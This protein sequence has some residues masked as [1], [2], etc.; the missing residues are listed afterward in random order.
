MTLTIGQAIH[1]SARLL[2]QACT[3]INSLMTMIQESVNEFDFKEDVNISGDW[4]YDHI[5]DD[6]DFLCLNY[7]A[8]LGLKQSR[9]KKTQCYL[10]IEFSL[11]GDG[12]THEE[13]NNQEPLVHISLWDVQTDYNNGYCF[14]LI[15]REEEN[16]TLQEEVLFNWSPETDNWAEQSWTYSLKLTSLNSL[17]DIK[18]K[19][20]LPVNKLII[21]NSATEAGLQ[22]IDGIVKYH[23][24]YGNT[25]QVKDE[26]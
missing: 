17:E 16:I 19:I 26:N 15:M 18:N 9:K 25:F 24:L 23:H 11:A 12:M 5:N 4:A 1:Q 8:S 3:E 7:A 21:T 2:S 20:I 14:S 22:A 13:T 6:S 10:N